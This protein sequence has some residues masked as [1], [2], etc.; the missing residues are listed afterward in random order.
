MRPAPD[1]VKRGTVV[2]INP[3]VPESFFPAMFI[4]VLESSDWGVE[5]YVMVPAHKRGEMANLAFYRVEW[6]HV[7]YVGES[8][9]IVNKTEPT[10]VND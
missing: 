5:G 10:T 6:E 1:L 2:Q 8:E 4:T 9:W 3:N 7:E